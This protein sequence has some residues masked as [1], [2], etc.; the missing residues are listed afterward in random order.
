MLVA[1]VEQ[2]QEMPAHLEC[3]A[4][5]ALPNRKPL[6]AILGRDSIRE[7]RRQERYKMMKKAIE[8]MPN[9]QIADQKGLAGISGR[10]ARGHAV[11][12]RTKGL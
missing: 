8:H 10:Q 3:G 11:Y 4:G 12:A 6:K 5:A 2:E 9:Q 1:G 7:R